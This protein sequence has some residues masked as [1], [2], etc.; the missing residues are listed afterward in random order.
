MPPGLR[1]G[2]A[3]MRRGVNFARMFDARPDCEVVA[4]CDRNPER[5]A[6]TAAPFEAAAYTEFEDLCTHDLDAVVIVTPAPAHAQCTITAARAGRHVLCEV[7]AVMTLE[8]AEAVVREVRDSGITYMFAENMCYFA[9]VQTMT[10]IVTTG[11]IGAPFYAEGEYIHDCRSLMFGRDDG[12]GGGEGDRPSWRASLPPIQYSTHDLGPLLT[13][14]DDRVVSAV[15]LDTGSHVTTAPPVIDVEAALFRTERGSVIKLLCGFSVEREPAF[16]FL[17][18]YGSRGSIE[19]DR[20][21][22]YDNLKAYFADI[23]HTTGLI[24]I[25]VSINHP[26]APREATL[27]GHG[28]SEYYMIQDFV[29][30]I[31]DGTQP[32]LDVGAAMRFTL[33]GICA[34]LS[35]GRG[36]TPV[37]IPDI[38]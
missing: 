8:E 16:H 14:M 31:L 9:C 27:G 35:A 22:P 12:L 15:G 5:A 11:R 30:S 28:T 24:D 1:I 25:P 3:G 21:R 18:L 20:Y 6:E 10:Q 34:H 23:P 7:P 38:G 13:M 2:I 36:G 19:T 33:P 26:R 4:I 32:A 29:R 17:S 37:E